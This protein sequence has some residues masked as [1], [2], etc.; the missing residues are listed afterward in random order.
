MTTLDNL[1][2]FVKLLGSF[3][4][5]ALICAVVGG[6]GW[7]G[8]SRLAGAIHEVAEVRLPS[9]R[10]LA[11][12]RNGLNVIKAAERTL[13]VGRLSPDAR[14]QQ[15]Q[16]IQEGWKG[17]EQGKAI[18]APLPQT[19]QEA[20]LWKNYLADFD[21]WQI[22]HKKLLETLGRVKGDDAA[23]LDQAINIALGSEQQ[24]SRKMSASLQEVIALNL[25]LADKA[26]H[27]GEATAA[28][29]MQMSLF[30]VIG[31]V[32]LAIALGLVLSRSIQSPLNRTVTMLDELSKGHLGQ[33]LRMQRRDEIGQM[34]RAMD[35]FADH[36]Q[37]SL[38]AALE[39]MAK[40]DLSVAVKLADSKDNI[41]AALKKTLDD[42]NST[43]CGIAQA[44][45]QVN[46]ASGEVSSASQSLSQGATQ[47]AAAI[48]EITSSMT[49]I[50]SQ[51]KINA[52]NAEE[53]NR[54]AG[55]ATAVA[56]EG[57]ERMQLMTEAMG[58]ISNAG[59][60]IS[61]IIKVIDEIAFQTNLLALNAAVEAARAGQHGKGF[62]VVAEEVRNLAARSAKAAAETAE[63]IEGSV[64]KT[65][66]GTELAEQ[67]AASLKEI[68][69]S[70]QQVGS[71]LENIA[72]ASREQAMG[73][74]QTHDALNQVDLV[75]QSNTANAEESAAAAE[76]LS[77]QAEQ[78]RMLVGTFTLRCDGLRGESFAIPAAPG[79]TAP[80]AGKAPTRDI[81]RKPRSLP[82]PSP[83]KA[84]A[85][86]ASKSPSRRA[87]SPVR[88]EP[89]PVWGEGAPSAAP[90]DPAKIIA[91][92]DAEFGK[93]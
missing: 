45:E 61:K 52:E 17:Y 41:G 85:A 70:V 87:P 80:P 67:T 75:T 36:L 66:R 6:V 39:K 51:T 30:T 74:S 62:A 35:A 38:V 55:K 58:E 48:E 92:D 15:M 3:L 4:L 76:E 50:A 91:L 77:S 27:E 10:G 11:L 32:L 2:M 23:A 90:V 7:R 16:N 1:K 47:Q 73:I 29:S 24:A 33:R 63:L 42:L 83:R 40:G 28:S 37:N 60:S 93:Y 14:T 46:A 65:R 79:R 13:L 82:S 44:G 34:A 84:A 49:E 81:P 57:N 71:L 26:G 59:Q 88:T 18:Y 54:L 19:P 43:V 56:R 31:G 89:E 53:A 12:M 5:I 86:F 22:E 68:V 21:R 9:V 20:A 25:K 78:M 72:T 69:S 8:T 64:G